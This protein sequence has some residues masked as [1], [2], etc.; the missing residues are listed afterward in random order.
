M[1]RARLLS[2]RLEGEVSVLA[3]T[4]FPG[5][6]DGAVFEASFF[7]PYGIAA[8]VTGDTLYVNDSGDI[9]SS[10][11]HPN[12]IRM[13]TGV[14]KAV[15]SPVA[16]EEAD[17]VPA[18]FVLEQ[19]YP[20]PFNPSTHIRFNLPQAG[21]VTLTVYDL[22]GREVATL[23]N[24]QKPAGNHEVAFDAGALA[25]GFYVYRLHAGRFSETKVM[26]LLK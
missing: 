24:G 22:F 21:P 13:I 5:L 25:S 9:N 26:T 17:E 10:T 11:V 15:T 3:G 8:S 7:R 16:N 2:R 1:F 20:N 18:G 14:H 23:V 19:N 6:T 4:G 12:V